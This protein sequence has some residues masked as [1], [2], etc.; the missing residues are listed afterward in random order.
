MCS[1]A[2]AGGAAAGSGGAEQQIDRF[3][4]GAIGAHGGFSREQH[5]PETG[6]EVPDRG[7]GEGEGARDYRLRGHICKNLQ[8]RPVRIYSRQRARDGYIGDDTGGKDREYS[9][10]GRC[11]MRKRILFSVLVLLVLLV[12]ST[13]APSSSSGRTNRVTFTGTVDGKRVGALCR[14]SL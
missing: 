10:H 13:R 3:P 2:G 7:G 8:V 5:P 1:T 12:I 11:E 6:G 9:I 4:A 14:S